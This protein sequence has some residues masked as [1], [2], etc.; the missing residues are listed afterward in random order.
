V[1][2]IFI[3]YRRDDAGGYAGPL[4]RDLR[5]ALGDQ[6]FQDVDRSLPGDRY[7]TR[8][9]RA[10]ARCDVFV[11]IV[12]PS[13]ISRDEH[14]RRRLDYPGDVLRRELETALERSDVVVMP[15]LVGGA[16][17][18][19]PDDLP[20]ELRPLLECTS[21][22]V[23]EGPQRPRSVA[24]LSDVIRGHLENRTAV[25]AVL[26]AIAAV[27]LLLW[28][29]R[30]GALE[31]WRGW[32]RPDE[33][34]LQALRLGAL[35]A[36]EWGVLAA[37]AAAAVA[38]VTGGRAGRA[39]VIGGLAAA[40]GGIVG[41]ALDEILREQHHRSLGLIAGVLITAPIAASGGLVGR[42]STR[43]V[44]AAALGAFVGSLLSF[45]VD[46]RFWDYGLPVLGAV[47]GFAAVRLAAANRAGALRRPRHTPT[48]PRRKVYY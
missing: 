15:V 23:D 31:L 35:H 24:Y 3:S 6:V 22:R 19:E 28:P 30:K 26:A 10:I 9:E 29:V 33:T 39:A 14:G 38:L 1:D 5:E 11:V 27:A 13:W 41:G 8:I 45:A 37:A 32:P 46:I 25:P 16:R 20:P 18:P 43:A 36:L 2:R 12:G 21:Y 4:V 44:I 17:Q 34:W 7:W 48:E 42:A 40:F 47:L